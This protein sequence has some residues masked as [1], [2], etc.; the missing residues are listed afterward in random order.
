ML[1]MNIAN[2]A[3]APGC[4]DHTISPS[5]LSPFVGTIKFALRADR[6]HRIPLP[7]SVTIAKRPS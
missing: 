5:A 4:Q 3:S 7:T 1:V 2:L 6:V